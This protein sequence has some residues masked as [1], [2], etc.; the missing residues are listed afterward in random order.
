MNYS[1]TEL[2]YFAWVNWWEV[3]PILDDGTGPSEPMGDYA[4]VWARNKS[5]ARWKAYREMQKPDLSLERWVKRWPEIQERDG[6]HPLHGMKVTLAVCPHGLCLLGEDR[7][8]TSD[9]PDCKEEWEAE[10]QRTL[11]ESE[12]TVAL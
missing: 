8:E 7:D 3:V 10:A 11:S 4:E 5:E 9:C 6:L 1:L 2:P 12:G